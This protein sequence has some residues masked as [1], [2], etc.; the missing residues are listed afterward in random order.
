MVD[1]VAL[2]RDS[3]VRILEVVRGLG[4]GE[5][6][7][8]TLDR[9]AA[10]VVD[11]LGFGAVVVNVKVPG[12]GLVVSSAT[13]PPEVRDMVGET[14]T[15]E[16]WLGLLEA[17][18]RWGELRTRTWR[19]SMPSEA[20]PIVTRIGRTTSPHH[21]MVSGGSGGRSTRFWRRCG[22]GRTRCWVF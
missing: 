2:R 9:I 4:V 14:M 22:P 5:G 8:V 15:H 11:V 20:C 10:A 19:T 13:G 18:E 16:V 17:C 7:D 3:L 1:D 6:L 21:R 12:G